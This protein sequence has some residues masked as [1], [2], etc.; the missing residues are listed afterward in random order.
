MGTDFL[1]K[2]QLFD[3]VFPIC[4]CASTCLLCYQFA[5]SHVFDS[6]QA[7]YYIPS[8]NQKPPKGKLYCKVTNLLA[9][10]VQLGMKTKGSKRTGDKDV[11]TTLAALDD[12]KVLPVFIG[13][14]RS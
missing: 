6:A 9:R 13:K 14:C 11:P 2:K 1:M 5:Y 7:T 10:R 12:G 3:M 8:Y 4:N